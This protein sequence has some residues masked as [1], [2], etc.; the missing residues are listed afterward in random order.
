MA[1]VRDFFEIDLSKVRVEGVDPNFRWTPHGYTREEIAQWIEELAEIQRLC[2]EEGYTDEDFQR[3]RSSSDPKERALGETYHKFYD[4]D[5]SGSKMN[6]DFIAVEWVGDHYEVTNG[7]HRVWMAQQ[8]GLRHIP[9]RVS[10]PDEATL[11]RL[12]EEG[13]R[14]AAGEQPKRS[15]TPVWERETPK[16]HRLERER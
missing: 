9:A 16:R 4:H 5:S 2:R 11:Q 6:H 10:A 14:V 1:W 12:R 3:M 15:S 13:E 8:M 7:R